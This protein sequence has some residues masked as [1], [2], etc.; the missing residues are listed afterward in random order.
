MADFR[1]NFELEDQSYS[2][3]DQ[4]KE[5]SNI[6]VSKVDTPGKIFTNTFVAVLLN[7]SSLV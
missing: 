7:M 2:S 4:S 5:T 6:P 1:F 3:E